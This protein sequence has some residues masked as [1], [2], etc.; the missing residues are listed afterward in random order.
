[1]R[2]GRLSISLTERRPLLSLWL[3]LLF[4]GLLCSATPAR[5]MLEDQFLY[6]PDR[7]LHATPAD[8][9]LPYHDIEFAATD[10]TRLHGWL[11]EGYPENPLVLICH[12]NAGNI[13]DRVEMLRFLHG[14]GLAVFIFDYRGYGRSAG[15]T[16]EE[17]TYADARG[18]LA[19]LAQQ[20]WST[21]RL[22][23]FG[24]S[25]GAGVALQLAI[26]QPPAALVLE[27]PF[28]SVAAMGRHHYPLLFLLAGWL[29]DARYDNLAKIGGLRTPLQ[30]IH[31]DSDEI[32]PLAMAR[33]LER[34]A[35]QPKRLS[36]IPGAGH[37]DL[38]WEF[39]PGYADLWRELVE[40]VGR[41]SNAD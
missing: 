17:G 18:A 11:L 26:E 20:G 19:W 6:F 15:S 9:H 25:L 37:N 33:E 23:Y 21:D 38:F 39:G 28:T 14:L 27:T 24:R 4:T 36:V 29:L 7:T 35:P 41:R 40:R 34:K 2:T 16:S 32:V 10:G 8:A 13:G 30:I 31:G 12:G 22:I 3:F 5:A 1:M